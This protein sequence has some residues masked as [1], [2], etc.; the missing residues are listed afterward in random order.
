M[1]C[2]HLQHFT[3][4]VFQFYR[5]IYHNVCLGRGFANFM[6]LFTLFCTCFMVMSLHVFHLTCLGTHFFLFMAF[7][8][9]FAVFQSCFSTHIFSGICLRRYLTHFAAFFTS[10]CGFFH[11][12]FMVY[13]AHCAAV[14]GEI[15]LIFTPQNTSSPY[16]L[17]FEEYMSNLHY[18][19][20]LISSDVCWMRFTLMEDSCYPCWFME[21]YFS[22]AGLPEV[23]I[24]KFTFKDCSLY[25][26]TM[27][28]SV[29]II[30][31]E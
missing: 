17:L 25:S 5:H 3:F 31:S 21:S 27:I 30:L 13:C 19:F 1:F 2:G 6:A 28:F 11:G 23:M 26:P 10:F 15:A 20:T 24:Q 9:L 4:T 16:L 29:Y 12:H 14:F 7:F 8:T 18:Y 22:T